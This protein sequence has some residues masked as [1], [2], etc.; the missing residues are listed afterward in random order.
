MDEQIRI[1]TSLYTSTL[2]K[3]L[4]RNLLKIFTDIVLM[5]V[6]CITHL[7]LFPYYLHYWSPFLKAVF[8]SLCHGSVHDMV[9]KSI[10]ILQLPLGAIFESSQSDFWELTFYSFF[11]SSRTASVW[12][13]YVMLLCSFQILLHHV[14][15]RHLPFDIGGGRIHE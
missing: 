3:Y 12:C 15:K 5:Y 13:S 1:M 4:V 10:P 2:L 14:K 8:M 11:Q 7:L 6:I 9:A